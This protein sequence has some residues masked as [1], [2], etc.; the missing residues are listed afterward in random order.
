[1][2]N[3]FAGEMFVNCV[4]VYRVAGLHCDREP[5]DCDE[6]LRSKP[7]TAHPRPSLWPE[8]FDAD[9]LSVE[10][11]LR[12]PY[13][14]VAKSTILLVVGVTQ[15]RGSRGDEFVTSSPV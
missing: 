9:L 12:F 14:A 8:P 10:I 13:V 3:A 7:M 1:M 2:F 4:S 15:T 11:W 5:S 6:P